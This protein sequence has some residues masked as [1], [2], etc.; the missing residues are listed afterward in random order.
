MATE[1]LFTSEEPKDITKLYLRMLYSEK[2][3]VAAKRVLESKNGSEIVNRFLRTV[4]FEILA[5]EQAARTRNLMRHLL[6]AA[7]SLNIAVEENLRYQMVREFIEG[8]AFW[9]SRGR[10]LTENFCVFAIEAF[11]DHLTD[12]GRDT[13][14]L[15]GLVSGILTSNGRPSPWAD[16]TFGKLASESDVEYAE[17]FGSKFRLVDQRG[18]LPTEENID[19][20]SERI[21]SIVSV[22][23]LKNG[24]FI[25][26]SMPE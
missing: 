4:N 5:L 8:G 21:D 13:I 2:Y 11:M 18:N 3:I 20:C 19:V 7:P 15:G 1:T 6:R 10:S 12:F 16:T 9:E 24:R 26:L 14:K 22:Q 25:A 23:H 17:S